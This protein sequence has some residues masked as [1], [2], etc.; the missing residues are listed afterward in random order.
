ML[1]LEEALKQVHS[2]H[3]ALK[4]GCL[5]AFVTC[6]PLI[7]FQPVVRWLWLV[8]LGHLAMT[9]LSHILFLCIAGSITEVRMEIRV[10]VQL[11]CANQLVS[12]LRHR[13]HVAPAYFT[14][15]FVLL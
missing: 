5:P 10:A 7:A 14:A 3:A 15:G 1:C 13:F 12:P 4:R 2:T 9:L 6:F 8:C 11:F